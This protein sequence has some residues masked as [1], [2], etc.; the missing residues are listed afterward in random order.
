MWR[1]THVEFENGHF[2]IDVTH[3][4]YA[5]LLVMSRV[6]ITTTTTTTITCNHIFYI[7]VV[8]CFSFIIDNLLQKRRAV[9][10]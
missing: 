2:K 3:F 7:V 5:L 8:V 4:S 10:P 6:F 9:A 1:K